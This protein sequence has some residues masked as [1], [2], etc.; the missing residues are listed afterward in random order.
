MLCYAK[1]IKNTQILT[2]VSYKFVAINI[3]GDTK[4]S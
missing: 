4:Q 2:F 1:C 3:E